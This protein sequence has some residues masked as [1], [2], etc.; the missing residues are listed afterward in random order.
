MCGRTLIFLILNFEFLGD[1]LMK[2]Y[3]EFYMNTK[4]KLQS[5]LEFMKFKLKFLSILSVIFTVSMLQ[6]YLIFSL[7]IFTG[8]SGFILA[9]LSSFFL[10]MIVY[11]SIYYILASRSLA[12]FLLEKKL[13]NFILLHILIKIYVRDIIREIKNAQ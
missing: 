2:L 5:S 13:K 7:K 1:I 11:F 4:N 9:I 10:I 12:L 6:L 3:K 8:F